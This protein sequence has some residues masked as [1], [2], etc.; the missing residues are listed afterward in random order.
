VQTPEGILVAT[1]RYV[2]TF[3]CNKDELKRN[4]TKKDIIN[5]IAVTDDTTPLPPKCQTISKFTVPYPR[6][7]GIHSAK[8]NQSKYTQTYQPR[9]NQ[10]I[11]LLPR[12]NFSNNRVNPR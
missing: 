8:H 1:G 6:P 3:I 4:M 7:T 11:P 10:T 9:N 5:A 2:I 12:I